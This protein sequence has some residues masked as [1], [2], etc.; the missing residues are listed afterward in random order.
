MSRIRASVADDHRGRHGGLRSA[1]VLQLPADLLA[2]H[3]AR[4]LSPTD[5]ATVAGTP[6]P[7]STVYR[8]AVL[9]VPQSVLDNER[10]V[11]DIRTTLAT[12][13]LELVEPPPL[14]EV[15]PELGGRGE[16]LVDLPRPAVLRPLPGRAVVVDAWTAL[17][18]LRAAARRPKPD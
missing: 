7:R 11:R 4:V 5:A 9:L 18:V 16:P 6:H 3:G 10:A 17:Q 8:S 13:G 2:R 12:I 1:A 14:G 15:A